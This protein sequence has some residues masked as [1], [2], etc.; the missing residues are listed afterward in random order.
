VSHGRRRGRRWCGSAAAALVALFVGGADAAPI[1]VR[2]SESATQGWVQLT[3]LTGKVLGHGELTQWPERRAIANRLVIH[4]DDGSLY[5][6]HVR[7]SQQGV[8]R[9]LSYRL[10]ERGPSFT[11]SSD[12]QFDR[13]GHYRASQ[14]ATPDAQEETAMGTIAIPDDASNGML[15]MLL[16]NLP[17]GTSAT[18]H[19]MAFTPK[20]RVL[21][22]HLTPEGRDPFS[23][24]SI[25]GTAI[26]FLAEPHVPG[27][28]GVMATIVGKQPP[29]VR[30]WTT[31]GR[32][33]V[34]VRFEGPLYADGPSWRI[35]QEVPRWPR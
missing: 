35:V 14:R 12:V 28:T 20:A 7:F 18:T 25:A 3:D 24:G 10:V 5:D 8:F 13:S 27:V 21:D 23:V 17:A 9:L 33:P 31:G 19:L 4:F 11:P 26:R 30:F 1:K 32:T 29:S 2:Y 22:L 15:S 16:R 6:E 34:F